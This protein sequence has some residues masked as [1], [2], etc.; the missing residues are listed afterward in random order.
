LAPIPPTCAAR[1]IT[2]VDEKASYS[3]ITDCSVVKSKSFFR[4][5]NTSRH[6]FA[7]S[8]S[9]MK[10]PRKPEP[11]VTMT[12]CFDQNDV[13]MSLGISCW[14]VRGLPLFQDGFVFGQKHVRVDHDLDQI[15]ETGFGFPVQYSLRF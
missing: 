13:D 10:P 3:L 11:P 4:G 14:G 1:W 6:P 9:T 2:M 5:T 7:R 8:F 12:F 15:L